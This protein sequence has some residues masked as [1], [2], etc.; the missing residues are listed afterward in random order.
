MNQ[1]NNNQHVFFSNLSILNLIGKNN[2]TKEYYN[3]LIFF[4]LIFSKGVHSGVTV[5]LLAHL[6]RLNIILI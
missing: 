6:L 3:W 2:L 1:K 5:L 4:L